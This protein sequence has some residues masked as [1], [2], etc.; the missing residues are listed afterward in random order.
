LLPLMLDVASIM[1]PFFLGVGMAMRFGWSF[2]DVLLSQKKNKISVC[3]RARLIGMGLRDEGTGA[4]PYPCRD[5][6][7]MR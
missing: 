5:K 4:H 7:V 2:F 6:F 1:R 3:V